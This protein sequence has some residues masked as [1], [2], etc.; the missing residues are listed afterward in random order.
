MPEISRFFGIVIY[1]YFT[2][3]PEPHFHVRYNGKWVKISIANLSVISGAIP[4]TA[5]KLVIEWANLH[6]DELMDAWNKAVIGVRP[7]KIPPLE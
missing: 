1:M 3:H 4:T 5:L 7:N 2:D 6:K